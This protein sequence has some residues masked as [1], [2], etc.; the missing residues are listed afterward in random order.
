MQSRRPGHNLPETKADWAFD[1]CPECNG[2][3]TLTQTVEEARA[4]IKRGIVS[5]PRC[6]AC[7]GTGRKRNK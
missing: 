4:A 7:G 3:G 5:A 6:P 1:K 2:T